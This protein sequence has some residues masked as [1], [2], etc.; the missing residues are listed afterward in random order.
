MYIFI[1]AVASCTISFRCWVSGWGKNMFGPR[2]N[3]QNIQKQVDVDILTY[4]NCDNQLRK[5]RLGPHFKLDEESFI[6]A[7]GENGK[8]ACTVCV[9]VPL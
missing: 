2:G 4:E 5:T 6:C 8:D 1:P 3:Y 7:G 9:Y